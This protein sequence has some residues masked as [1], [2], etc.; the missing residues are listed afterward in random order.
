MTNIKCIDGSLTG[1]HYKPGIKF[2]FRL[3]IPC[4]DVENYALLIEHDGQNDANVNSMLKL[5]DEGKAPYCVSVGVYPGTLLLPDGT[6]RQMRM[7]SYDLF[8]RE[9]GDFL[10][11]E[12][13]PYIEKTYGINFSK[14][15]DMHIA[16]GGSSGG[17]SAFVIAWFHSD[18][19]HRVYMSSPSFLAM[20]R[21]NE[22]PY[23]V[24]KYETKPI[25]VY[26]EY[27]EN[28]PNEYFGWSRGIDE[29]ARKALAFANYDFKY[30]F[31]AGEGHCSR[32]RDE[33]EAYERN[34]WIW[35]DWQKDSIAARGNSARVDK[36]I[37]FGS[38]WKSCEQFPITVKEESAILSQGYGI[39]VLSNDGK[40][41]YAA[42]ENDDMV[43]LY[44]KEEDI[45]PEKRI[46]HAT[47]HT[48]PQQ[49]RKGAID[50]AVD[51]TDRLFVLTEMG[52]QCVRSFGLVDVILELPD[53]SK[54]QKIAVTDA[55]YV[56]TA[57]GIYK[58]AL[59][60]ECITDGAEKRKQISYY[61]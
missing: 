32:Y 2:G 6:Q 42:N 45:L 1:N 26:E 61:D 35:R 43:Y 46:L 52:I 14:S 58:R 16:S 47:L 25:R 44:V 17:I 27:S 8:D 21:G 49:K 28:E 33:A 5:A 57:N 55:L 22:I 48:I 10:V 9:Y 12:L 4:V 7:N 60:E 53:S 51:K 54:P 59:Q 13:I 31:F 41:W 29:E 19:F 30:K 36:I 37:P 15:P 24:R 20:G 56:Q 18:Y 3:A 50:M 39:V 11:Y 23:L 34:E 38:K 40:V